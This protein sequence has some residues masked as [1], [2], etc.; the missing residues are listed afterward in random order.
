LSEQLSGVRY[1]AVAFERMVDRLIATFPEPPAPAVLDTQ[2]PIFLCGPFRSGSTLAEQVLARH[3]DVLAGGE[4]ETV[5]AIAASLQ[6]YPEAATQL[7][8]E[9]LDQLRTA[10]IGEAARLPGSGDRHTDKR[11]D[12][13]LHLG[14]IQLI[15]PGAPMVHTSRHP[16]D[17]LLSTLF[18]RFGE[19]VSYGHR[20]EDA[21]HQA[22]QHARLM[23]HWR[24]IMP[25]R[26]HD[27]HYEELVSS[28]EQAMKPLADFLGLSWDERLLEGG[29]SGPV[30]TASNWQ[31]RQPL[32]ARSVGRW[33]HYAKELEPARRLLETGGV[34]LPV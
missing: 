2:A 25:E 15:F 32:H 13:Y 20:T 16:L 19:G 5:P 10:Y 11:C 14:L 28:P 33:H 21:A 3:P 34:P 6:P 22:I 12:N 18:L 8:S 27:L 30:R 1:D 31:V 4:L 26:I 7:R 29:T 23:R 17:T 24:L 9:I